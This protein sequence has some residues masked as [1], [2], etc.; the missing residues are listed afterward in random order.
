MADSIFLFLIFIFSVVIHEVA[1]GSIAYALG[2]PTAQKLGRLTLNPIPH[3]DPFGSVL[4]P[5]IQ[6]FTMGTIFIAW[7]KPVPYNPYNLRNQRWGPA[8]VGVAGPLSNLIVALAFGLFFHF[9]ILPGIG[10][11]ELINGVSPLAI[12]ILN[13]VRTN[14][15]LAVFNLLP[16][17][18]LDGSHLL[19][20]VLPYTW[21]QFRYQLER[22]GFFILLALLLVMPELIGR[23]IDPAINFLVRLLTGLPI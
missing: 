10:L 21:Y 14:V 16:I 18:P 15:L 8:L 17:P 12:I 1:H 19:M 2:D 22:Y 6:Y 4:F 20:S 5:L 3:I 9:Y 11:S 13:I 7:A 23:I